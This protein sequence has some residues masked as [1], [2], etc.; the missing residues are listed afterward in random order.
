INLLAFD[1][2]VEEIKSRLRILYRAAASHRFQTNNGRSVPK[3]VNLDMQEYRDLRLTL[4][5]FRQTL[6]EEE[7]R[8]FH[9]GIVLQA[10]LPDA[11]REQKDL[12]E[13]AVERVGAGGAPIKIRIVKGANLAMEKVDAALH[14]W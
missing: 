4:A 1:D 10:Y 8:H 5:A 9:A 7:F 11:H 14:G 13:W 3:F 6:E 12:T 2:T